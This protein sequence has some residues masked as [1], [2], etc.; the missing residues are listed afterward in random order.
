MI[1]LSL[2]R[3]NSGAE[4]ALSLIVTILV[5]NVSS[6][7]SELLDSDGLDYSREA[8]EGS[9]L[10]SVLNN[11]MLNE[12]LCQTDVTGIVI[13]YARMSLGFTLKVAFW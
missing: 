11:L 2:R 9:K 10:C 12:S 4:F 1:L 7:E 6:F 13:S 5:N 8:E 3:V